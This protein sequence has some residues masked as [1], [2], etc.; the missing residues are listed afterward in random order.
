MK[1][2]GGED[3][4]ANSAQIL[5]EIKMLQIQSLKHF[6]DILEEDI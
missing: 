6:Q 5:N 3:Q 1:K 4:L 2:K